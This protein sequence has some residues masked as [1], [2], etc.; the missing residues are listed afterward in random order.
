[1][2]KLDEFTGQLE[3]NE[4]S[5]YEA[6]VSEA[7]KE[8]ADL[9]SIRGRLAR[10]AS[11]V[12]KRKEENRNPGPIIA[13]FSKAYLS[14]PQKQEAL[15]LAELSL[16]FPFP[17]GFKLK[18]FLDEK[19][20]FDSGESSPQF[21]YNLCTVMGL[22]VRLAATI[23]IQG[24]VN[25]LNGKDIELNREVVETLRAP[26][27]GSWLTLARRLAKRLSKEENPGV[28]GNLNH[29][30]TTKI[31]LEGSKKGSAT[32][33]Q[34][35]ERLVGFRNRLVHGER[36]AKNDLEE[37]V[38]LLLASVRGFGFLAEF[39]LMIRRDEGGFRL[40]GLLPGKVGNVNPDLP[41]D[42]PCL[43]SQ[44][45]P[46]NFLS[47]S[48][49]L[50][51]QEGNIDQEV[52]FDELFF[53][54]AGSSERLTYIA[55]R[56]ARQMDG[57]SLGSY[58]VFQD[59]M[60]QIP[61]PPVPK[62]PRIDF[63]E[64]SEFHSRLFV[65]R[66][67]LFEEVDNFVRERPTPYGILKALAGV[68][69]TAVMAKLYGSNASKEDEKIESGDRWAFH[70]C[71]HADGLDNPVVAMRSLI[72]QICDMFGKD[73]SPWL[74]NDLEELRDQKFPSIIAFAARELQK[75]ER[76]VLAIDAL[77]EGIELDQDSIPSIL[78]AF[79]PDGVIF[80]TSYRVDNKKENTRVEERL[81]QISGE[82]RSVLSH[83]NPLKGLTKENVE[84]FLKKA[85][86]TET[87]IPDALEAVWNAST[88]DSEGAADPFYLRF[89]AEGL[90]SGQISA[91]RPET[92]PTS[93]DDAFDEI[94][95]NLPGDRDFLL[96]R[97]LCT[98]AVMFDYA[99]DELFAELFSKDLLEGTEP[100]RADDI[101]QLRSQVG[102]LLVY[103]GDRYQLFHDRFRTFLVGHNQEKSISTNNGKL[104]DKQIRK[105]NL[106]FPYLMTSYQNI[107]TNSLQNYVS[108][109][110]IE[111]AIR[112]NDIK[113]ATNILSD[114][115]RLAII[116]NSINELEF[117]RVMHLTKSDL[118]KIVKNK[119]KNIYDF[120][121]IEKLLY[122]NID[123]VNRISLIEVQEN[124]ESF[125]PNIYEY[126]LALS[127]LCEKSLSCYKNDDDVGYKL[128]SD[129]EIIASY[130]FQA[131][132]EGDE[133]LLNDCK[134]SNGSHIV[135]G[136][137]K[138]YLS[139][140]QHLSG[141]GISEGTFVKNIINSTTIEIN[142]MVEIE[143][144]END[145][146]T[147]AFS[148]NKKSFPNC[149]VINGTN[150]ME[151]KCEQFFI[152]TGS[153]VSGKGITEGTYV[154]EVVDASVTLSQDAN[155]DA[156]GI[157]DSLITF[158]N[159]DEHDDEVFHFSID[160]DDFLEIYDSRIKDDNPDEDI[161]FE[162]KDKFDDIEIYL[163]M[164]DDEDL[165]DEDLDDEDLDDE[166]LDDEDLDDEDL[167][168]EER[169]ERSLIG[170][171]ICL[172]ELY[173]QLLEDDDFFEK[174]GRDAIRNFINIMSLTTLSYATHI[175][176][177]IVCWEGMEDDDGF[178]TF[179]VFFEGSIKG[180]F[181]GELEENYGD[182]IIIELN[183]LIE[184]DPDKF[185]DSVKFCANAAFLYSQAAEKNK[186]F[187]ESLIDFAS[188]TN[189]YKVIFREEGD[190]VNAIEI[191]NSQVF[192]KFKSKHKNQFPKLIGKIEN[193]EKENQYHN[194]KVIFWYKK[195]LEFNNSIR[196]DLDSLVYALTLNVLFPNDHI[197]GKNEIMEMFDSVM[198]NTP[199][200]DIFS[201]LLKIN[202]KDDDD[203]VAATEKNSERYNIILDYMSEVIVDYLNLCKEYYGESE[204]YVSDIYQIGGTIISGSSYSGLDKNKAWQLYCES[205]SKEMIQTKNK[206]FKMDLQRKIYQ[207]LD[208]QA[209]GLGNFYDHYKKSIE[210]L[211]VF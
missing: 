108:K 54:N 23:G 199:I 206:N 2:M 150:I 125:Y 205:V 147:L 202:K 16:K 28:A 71:M 188:E 126:K 192:A 89:V 29:A 194:D 103:N 198:Q 131:L 148:G 51:F 203:D 19:K 91:H 20:H 160:D 66:E 144:F 155:A 98:L 59:F 49:I 38:D 67:E 116:H 62:N 4:K 39:D 25:I 77:D 169:E 37:A 99:D 40:N 53:L 170:D 153:K 13:E 63:T 209:L 135:T 48:P 94:W 154:T 109:Y 101:A 52:T 74:S 182:G 42:Q 136:S 21:A 92:V 141:K 190:G 179:L 145:E 45:D 50:H 128:P 185:K 41:V 118:N 158:V 152:F 189:S 183:E 10:L 187:I 196:F 96:H 186:M 30:L 6:L 156:T 211:N 44:K 58:D 17:L 5:E 47:L 121:S 178:E 7:Q 43:V 115:Q 33:A 204:K 172:D 86:A 102:K 84:E 36:I 12:L 46:K 173:F 122:I 93:L 73:R 104:R 76:L 163:Y 97:M 176:E 167:D 14:M 85:S 132:F 151:L 69:K 134:I 193:L 88:N 174:N 55:Y 95:I 177:H 100:L 159:T 161:E 61:S 79:V 18:S 82:R 138:N 114:L 111:H 168:D 208:E 127:K 15:P 197:V 143:V 9:K 107:V 146:I 165:D 11:L 31:S 35:L 57:R 201:A 81:E 171:K 133:L 207:L 181:D 162:Y 175:K 87:I 137:F 200:Q 184:A 90:D 70:F 210:R 24:Y 26:A 139:I 124:L 119:I 149:K 75:G 157:A 112:I 195:A 191:N 27:D 80:L 65:G 180:F 110:S 22:L 129:D 8:G 113:L 106:L 3:K 140:G 32:L 117:Y 83:S 1:M 72:A 164:S 123:L 130:D 64:L 60:K 78:P 166:D 120:K 68:G 105:I 34:A 142:Q 56:Y